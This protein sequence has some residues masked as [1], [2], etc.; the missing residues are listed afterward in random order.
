ML[1]PIIGGVQLD[2]AA[3]SKHL[4]TFIGLALAIVGS[5]VVIWRTVQIVN[6]FPVPKLTDAEKRKIQKQYKDEDEENDL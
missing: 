1:V 3:H 4:F 6:R 2:H 5:G